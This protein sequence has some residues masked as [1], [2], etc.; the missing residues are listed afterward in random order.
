MAGHTLLK[1]CE[2][3]SKSSRVQIL[4]DDPKFIAN[5]GLGSDNDFRKVKNEALS[6][7]ASVACG[8]AGETKQRLLKKRRISK[9]R[10][11]RRTDPMTS[12]SRVNAVTI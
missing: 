2:D 4:Q 9:R 11:D 5:I 6:P 8:R 12:L 3:A 7:T 1:R 10:T